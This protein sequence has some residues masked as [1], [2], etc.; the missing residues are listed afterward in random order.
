ME[1]P[2]ASYKECKRN[3]AASIGHYAIDGCGEFLKG[4]EDGTP[5]A[6]LCGACGCHR[7]FHRKELPSLCYRPSGILRRLH[8]PAPPP[9]PPPP[10]PAILHNEEAAAV[11]HQPNDIKSETLS[12]GEIEVEMSTKKRKSRITK[13]QRNRMTA[14]A[15]RLGWRPQRHDE[16]EIGHFCSQLGI[17]CH[18]FKVWVGHNRRRREAHGL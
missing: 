4:G 16:E 5:E 11:N 14:F 8:Q 12:A 18:S 13:E 10:P 17:T 7:S 3:H 1:E 9:P 2:A 6:L 15:E